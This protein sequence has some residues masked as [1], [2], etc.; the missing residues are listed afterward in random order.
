[1]TTITFRFQQEADGSYF[2]AWD[3]PAGGGITTAGDSLAELQTNIVEAVQCH[4]DGPNRPSRLRLHFE[5]DVELMA[6]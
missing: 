5:R 4:F 1:M 6:A 3:D 2:A